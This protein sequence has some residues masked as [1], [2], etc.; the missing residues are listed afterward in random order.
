MNKKC[1]K[2]SWN[3]NEKTQRKYEIKWIKT[4][5][6]SLKLKRLNGDKKERKRNKRKRKK[7][8]NDTSRHE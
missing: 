3:K 6:G 5:W 1:R 2:K 8:K 7:E 4:F